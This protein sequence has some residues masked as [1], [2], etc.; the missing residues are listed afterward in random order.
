MAHQF[1]PGPRQGGGSPRVVSGCFT[2]LDPEHDELLPNFAF[3]CSLR[4]CSMASGAADGSGDSGVYE[5]VRGGLKI[6][7]RAMQEITR[8]AREER[9]PYPYNFTV[10]LL[11]PC[12]HPPS[13]T[14]QVISHLLCATQV[15]LRKWVKA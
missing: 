12:H 15:K 10:L 11:F 9:R 8:Q 1:V 14:S 2:G 5:M 3:N 13:E 7:T 6:Y 4:P